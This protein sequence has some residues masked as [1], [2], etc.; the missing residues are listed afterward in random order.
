LADSPGEA[1]TITADTQNTPVPFEGPETAQEPPPQSTLIG[2]QRTA[3]SLQIY[4]VARAGIAPFEQ[5]PAN[6][7]IGVEAKQGAWY[8]ISVPSGLTGWVATKFLHFDGDTAAVDALGLNVRP[9]PENTPASPPLGSYAAG[10][11]VQVVDKHR[12]WS[13]VAIS[14][15]V[16]VWVKEADL[17]RAL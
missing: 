12:A 10:A 6:S 5:L 13:R 17:K 9:L 1:S 4:A 11:R 7:R 14:F 16:T 3:R 2:P 8:K 15:P